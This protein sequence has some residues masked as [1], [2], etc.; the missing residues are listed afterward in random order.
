[1]RIMRFFLSKI[2]ENRNHLNLFSNFHKNKGAISRP[3]EI[4]DKEDGKNAPKQFMLNAVKF[5]KHTLYI[6]QFICELLSCLGSIKKSDNCG[7]M[8]QWIEVFLVALFFA[9]SGIDTAARPDGARISD[10]EAR[11]ANVDS[12]VTNVIHDKQNLEAS[13]HTDD[14]VNVINLHVGNMCVNCVCCEKRAKAKHYASMRMQVS[15]R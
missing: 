2:T 11:L 7:S 14:M 1:M 12:T 8:H 13:M 5:A 9:F 10:L 4:R 6:D 3:H 15:E